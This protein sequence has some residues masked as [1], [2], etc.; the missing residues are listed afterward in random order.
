LNETVYFKST[1]YIEEAKDNYTLAV[2]LGKRSV[3]YAIYNHFNEL[4]YFADFTTKDQRDQSPLNHFAG[5]IVQ[6]LYFTHTVIGIVEEFAVIPEEYFDDSQLSAYL[7]NQ[8]GKDYKADYSYDVLIHPKVRI[9]YKK[10]N[11]LDDQI[12]KQ[13]KRCKIYNSITPLIQNTVENYTKSTVV[14]NHFFEDRFDYICLK[15]GIL[16]MAN[17]YNAR[18][19]ANY[20]YFLLNAL[21]HNKIP[22]NEAELYFAGIFSNDHTNFIKQYKDAVQLVAAKKEEADFEAHKHYN[23]SVLA[24]CA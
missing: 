20:G 8:L 5:E 13:F 10:D 19:S 12:K 7:A 14:F 3:Q 15:D 17:R 16:Q 23:L 4:K 21:R 1:D 9:V 24:K 6:N 22:L 11:Q 18:S 2:L